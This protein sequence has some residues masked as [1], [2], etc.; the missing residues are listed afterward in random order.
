MHVK[1]D[2]AG[3]RRLTEIAVLT[4]GRDGRVRARRHGTRDTRIRLW[5]RSIERSDRQSGERHDRVPALAMALAVI[6]AP[7]SAT[8][9]GAGR[10]V[11]APMAPPQGRRGRR[12]CL[13]PHGRHRG[14]RAYR[15]RS[16]C[17]DRRRDS[18]DAAPARDAASPARCG[19]CGTAGSF[20]CPRRRVAGRR[21]SGRRIRCRGPRGRRQRRRLVAKHRRAG[22]A[23]CR[24]GHRHARVP[25]NVHRCPRIGNSLAVCWQ[26]GAVARA[27]ASPR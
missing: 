17:R 4:A 5:R 27:G 24:C 19:S 2:R 1:R 16:G 7:G 8:T 12:R 25:R 21:A 26:L 22:A 13:R 18:R 9:P 20:G 10:T 6:I 15:C 3:H 14:R 11:A 23:R